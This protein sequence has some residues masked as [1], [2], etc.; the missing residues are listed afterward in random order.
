[1]CGY[2]QTLDF[3]HSLFSLIF[4]IDLDIAMTPLLTIIRSMIRPTA[5]HPR[6]NWTPGDPGFLQCTVV[7]SYSGGFLLNF[8]LRG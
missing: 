1:M 6:I 4:M 7:I 3:V 5:P 8:H 2:I